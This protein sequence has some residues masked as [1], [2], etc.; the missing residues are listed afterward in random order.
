MTDDSL[1]KLAAVLTTIVIV[2]FV[3]IVVAQLVHALH[4]G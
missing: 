3:A 2:L 4:L 1:M